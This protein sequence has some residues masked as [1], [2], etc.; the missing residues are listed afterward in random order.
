M[1]DALARE[2]VRCVAGEQEQQN[3]W[4]KL[5]QAN[6]TE[7]ERAMR[8][9]IDLPAHRDGLHFGRRGDQNPGAHEIAEVRIAEGFAGG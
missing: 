5:G 7:I 4:G 6:Q 2:A 1:Q 3:A 8:E 9:R